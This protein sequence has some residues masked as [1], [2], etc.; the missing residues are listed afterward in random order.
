[1]TQP[2]SCFHTLTGT[3][4]PISGTLLASAAVSVSGTSI[5]DGSVLSVNNA[6]VTFYIDPAR[7]AVNIDGQSVFR[8]TVETIDNP[9]AQAAAASSI[10]NAVTNGISDRIAYAVK[11]ILTMKIG[12]HT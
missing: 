7:T 9:A 1:V 2:L 12:G 4:A 6:D 10:S 5:Y 11:R 3:G 8:T